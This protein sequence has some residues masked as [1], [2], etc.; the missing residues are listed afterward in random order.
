MKRL[1]W[2]LSTAAMIF[3]AVGACLGAGVA[4]AADPAPT[5]EAAADAASETEAAAPA[6]NK[7]WYRG[8]FGA[9]FDGIWND[10]GD[11]DLELNQSLQFQIDPPRHERLHLRGSLWTIENLGSAPP[12]YSGLRGIDDAYDSDILLRASYLYLDIDDLW[13][14]STLRIGRQRIMEGAA[15]NRVDGVYF[16]QRLNAWDWYVFGGTRASF[17]DDEFENPVAGGGLSFTP[18]GKTKVALDAYWGREDR[19]IGNAR[20]LHGPIAGLLYRLTDDDVERR[21][22]DVS[23]ALSV[24]QT[25]NEKLS[26]FGRLNWVDDAGTEILLSA[27]G[28]FAEPCDITYELT[29]RHQFN[30][31]GDRTNDVTGYYRLLGTYESYDDVFLALHRPLT[32]RL[33]LSLETDIHDSHETN[34]SN[35]DYQRYA[36]ILSGNKLFDKAALDAR[37]GLERWNVSGGEGT[38]AVTGEVGRQFNQVYVAAGADYQR[39]EDRVTLDN[40]PL[41]LLDMARAWFAPGIL[42]GYNP[43]MLFY[44]RYTV[45]MHENIYTLYAKTKWSIGSDQDLQAKITFENDDRPDSP[46][47]RVQADYTI[48]F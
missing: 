9:G 30:S 41:L 12:K 6:E 43:L 32:E 19:S 26:L 17:Y 7:K 2:R 23:V 47:W 46:I 14:D 25:V 16:K 4:W 8:S 39:Y 37:I 20:T 11:H 31:I 24:W 42:Q 44:E 21:V 27:T 29:Y 1:Y 38:W 22:D 5:A 15:Y 35:R 40:Q 10:G 34:W 33:M 18:S 36:L 13:N 45:E 3:G 48:R 28:Y